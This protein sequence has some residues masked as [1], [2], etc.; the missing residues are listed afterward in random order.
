[1]I[2][3]RQL[4]RSWGSFSLSVTLRAEPKDYLV[5]LGPSGCGKSLLLGTVAGIYLPERGQVE[6]DGRD[7]TGRPP[8]QRNVGFVFQKVSLFPHLS[9]EGNIAFG[10][11]SRRLDRVQRKQ[12]VDEMVQALEIDPLLQRPV[13]ALSGGEAQKVAIARA[14]A[15]KPSVLLLDE[16]LSLVDHNTR[17]EL[18]QVLRQI[19][20]S[21]GVTVLHV[22]HNRQEARAQG[23]RCAVMLG[24]RIVQE[25]VTEDVFTHPRCLFVARFLGYEGPVPQSPGCTEACLAGTGQCDAPYTSEPAHGS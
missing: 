15:P 10:L 21:T 25:G 17:L 24:G 4:R 5:I 13:T 19:H 2:Q 18:Q 14:L 22:T 3:L 20:Q 6:L 8:E 23:Q 12:R 7:V 1:V 16:P 11:K 9:V